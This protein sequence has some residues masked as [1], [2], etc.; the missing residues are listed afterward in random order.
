MT[1]QMHP[2]AETQSENAPMR[3]SGYTLSVGTFNCSSWSMR[4]W[5]GMRFWDFDYTVEIMGEDNP[6]FEH[7]ESDW[8]LSRFVE[9]NGLFLFSGVTGC[10]PDYTVSLDPEEQFRDAFSFLADALS[11][12]RLQFSDVVELT[13]YHVDLRKHVAAFRRVK[14]E[15]MVAPYPAWS[16][17]GTTELITPGTLVELRVMA[18]R[19]DN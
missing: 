10:R 4:A 12:A 8:R 17:I 2:A 1:H 16:C 11:A 5:A 7:F 18:S 9:V 13:S 3:V 19:R 15:F 6:D 14:D